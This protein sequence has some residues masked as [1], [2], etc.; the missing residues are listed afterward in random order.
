MSAIDSDEPILDSRLYTVVRSRIGYRPHHQY[1]VSIALLVHYQD[2]YK[3]R[4]SIF[5]ELGLFNLSDLSIH[6][7]MIGSL[8][9]FEHVE[10]MCDGWAPQISVSFLEM[11]TT[12][13]VP[14]V[15]GFYL[16]LKDSQHRAKLHMR[17]D[18]D[19]ITDVAA[20]VE[21][22]N[23]CYGDSAVHVSTSPTDC[24][25]QDP[26]F[27]KFLWNRNVPVPSFLADWESSVTSDQAMQKILCNFDAV[28]FLE[29]SALNLKAP[30]DRA[31]SLAAH[32]SGVPF[33]TS[34]RWTRAFEKTRLSLFG[35]WYYHIHYVP[36]EKPEFVAAIRILMYGKRCSIT[37]E[38][39]KALIGKKLVFGRL[40]AERIAHVI[41]T[42]E[43][44]VIGTN[45]ENE[46][47][48]KFDA[49]AIV[50]TR[51]DGFPMTV[52]TSVYKFN[53]TQMFVGYHLPNES[54]H[55]LEV[56]AS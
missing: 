6:I 8:G 47:C 25:K 26:N 38:D 41:L 22:L 1:D 23:S 30:G 42:S 31:L 10:E 36:W 29:D 44:L 52:F 56:N 53:D 50:F 9:D 37:E 33:A 27:I 54:P 5:K 46:A 32:V 15:N 2:K 51:P 4:L 24:E 40:A 20:T 55:F 21:H 11:G 45:N 14:K 49:N 35:G 12:K 7:V 39:S 18:D 28:R 19:S 43:G 16:W 17:I 13:I 34:T 48:W 3:A